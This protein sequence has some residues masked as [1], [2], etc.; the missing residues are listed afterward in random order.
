MIINFDEFQ[1]ANQSGR[2]LND[3]RIKNLNLF[4]EKG[5]RSK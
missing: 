5:F 4:K 2:E 1:K 3:I